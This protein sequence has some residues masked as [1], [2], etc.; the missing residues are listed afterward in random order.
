MQCVNFPSKAV[1]ARY[2][3]NEG[4][5]RQQNFIII[6]LREVPKSGAGYEWGFYVG[7]TLLGSE[8]WLRE[9][10]LPRPEEN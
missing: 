7:S 2:F 6:S 9:T 1:G 8:H 3:C 5:F 10:P 4:L